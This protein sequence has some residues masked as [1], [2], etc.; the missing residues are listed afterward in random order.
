MALNIGFRTRIVVSATAL[1]LLTLY[2]AFAVIS[3]VVTRGQERHLDEALLRA[4]TEEVAE[5][6]RL[7]RDELALGDRPAL[8]VNEIGTLLTKYAAIYDET[9]KVRSATP[10]FGAEPARREVLNHPVG[11]CFD[12]RLERTTVRAVLS[13]IPNHPGTLLL[14]AA[15]RAAVDADAGFLRKAMGLVF[16]VAVAWTV[17]VAIFIARRLS[18]AHR[19]M[20]RVVR[21]VAAGNLRAR[22]GDARASGD[23]AQLARD[24]DDMIERLGELLDAQRVFIAHAAHELRSPLT[25]LYGELALALRRARD[26]GEYRR[27]I[28]TAFAS[29]HELKDLADDLLAVA[30]LGAAPP[31]A[32]V[33]CDVGEALIEA[34]RFV[35]P[36]VGPDG[37]RIVMVGACGLVRATDRDLVRL[38]RNLLEN[39]VR[40]S[41][42]GGT[43]TC[44]LGERGPL[45]VITIADEGPGVP[46]PARE[47]IFAPFYRGPELAAPRLHGAE[48]GLGLTIARGIA[49]AYGGE[50]VLDEGFHQGARFEITLPLWAGARALPPSLDEA[51]EQRGSQLDG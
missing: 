43:V 8:D 37:V 20:A 18:R 38:L 44:E 4:A 30:R 11:A 17:V 49:R 41:P 45:A 7:H 24:I 29:T 51:S 14:M 19:H 32:T 39:A 9:G 13:A 2:A 6:S 50:V 33:Q 35:D 46:V 36:V 12:L 26:A 42:V 16:A 5:A 22:V 25:T 3:I 40:H 48:S 23:E 27:A 47:K 28:E 1:T 15:P 34:R 10:A 31:P 21:E